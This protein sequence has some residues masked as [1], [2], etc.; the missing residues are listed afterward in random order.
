MKKKRTWS[1]MAKRTACILTALCVTAAAVQGSGVTRKESEGISGSA[2]YFDGTSASS[3]KLPDAVNAARDDVT[4]MAWIKCDDDMFGGSTDK[5]Y[6]FQQTG[7]GRSILYLDS[8]MKLGTCNSQRCA[9]QEPGSR[10][11]MGACG[12]YK[13]PYGEKSTVLYQWKTGK[14]KHVGR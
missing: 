2:A 12:I 6:L 7:A 5:K 1:S 13:Q 9:E 14:R 8:N 3:L 4:L 10:R 11:Q